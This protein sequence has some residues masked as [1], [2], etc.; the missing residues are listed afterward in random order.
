MS[1]WREHWQYWC[2][3]LEHRIVLA[4][5]FRALARLLSRRVPRDIGFG[6]FDDFEPFTAEQLVLIRKHA[7]HGFDTTMSNITYDDKFFDELELTV[8]E[9]EDFGEFG[10]NQEPCR[11]V[12]ATVIA[13]IPEFK[14][15]RVES[16]DGYQYAITAKTAGIDFDELQVGQSLRMTVD[17]R[18]RVLHAAL[19]AEKP[20]RPVLTLTPAQIALHGGIT[21]SKA[22]SLENAG[23]I[24]LE[25]YET[26]EFVDF[27]PITAAQHE[28][29]AQ[30]APLK[31]GRLIDSLLPDDA[32]ELQRVRAQLADA[33]DVL[34]AKEA[35]RIERWKTILAVS[36]GAAGVIGFL[37]AMAGLF[38]A[39]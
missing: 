7:P 20:C 8:P 22:L 17:Q 25:K 1:R 6:K 9:S 19:I 26:R 38:F 24:V 12:E 18:G 27:E 10:D 15:V 3:Q 13:L 39:R 30:A 14:Q 33:A 32:E 2:F 23:K 5:P 37:I 36:A 4:W 11:F 29:L 34:K 28:A 16:K 31:R 21:E 35:Q